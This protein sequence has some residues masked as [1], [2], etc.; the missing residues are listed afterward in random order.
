MLVKTGPKITGLLQ[1][2]A[3]VL[4]YIGNLCSVVP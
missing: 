1:R 2:A 3:T 4:F